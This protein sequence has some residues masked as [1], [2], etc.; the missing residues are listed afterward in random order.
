[1]TAEI[2]DH[3]TQWRNLREIGNDFN[4]DLRGAGGETRIFTAI[5]AI[6]KINRSNQFQPWDR[7]QFKT[8]NEGFPHSASRSDNDNML[9]V[10]TANER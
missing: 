3:V 7:P 10:F 9:H 4:A 1:V 8:A 5:R 2:D 6:Q